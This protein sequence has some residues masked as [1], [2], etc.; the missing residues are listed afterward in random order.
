MVMPGV[1]GAVTGAYLLTEIDGN[2]IKPFVSVYLLVM[3]ILILQKAVGKKMERKPVKNVGVLALAGGFLDS[4]GGGGWGPVVT[5]TLLSRGRNPQYIIGTV[6]ATE[7]FVA[8]ASAGVFT[9][10]L[11]LQNIQV[12][13]GLIMGGL[14]A[15]PFGAL[16]VGKI[17]PRTLMTIVG[18]LVIALSLRN[19]IKYFPL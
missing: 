1:L 17:K 11:G 14:L 15:A 7:F 10:F 9:L 18:L 5:S 16:L 19:L 13:A 2:L 4:V 12:I 3:G 8:F 6:N